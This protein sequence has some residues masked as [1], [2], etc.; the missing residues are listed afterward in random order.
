M[1][2]LKEKENRQAA[3]HIVAKF[4]PV[5]CFGSL[6]NINPS[7]MKILLP[8]FMLLTSGPI[9]FARSYL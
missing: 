8:P 9:F 6:I 3:A 4:Y 5:R 2:P 1:W 7:D